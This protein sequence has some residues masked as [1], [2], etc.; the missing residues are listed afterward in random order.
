MRK[1]KFLQKSLAVLLL[2]GM[3]ISMKSFT[4]GMENL[5]RLNRTDQFVIFEILY[6]L[7][8]L[9]PGSGSSI[10]IPNEMVFRNADPTLMQ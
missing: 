10:W 3:R 5:D 2:N 9:P 6:H 1:S 8:C 7:P 4:N